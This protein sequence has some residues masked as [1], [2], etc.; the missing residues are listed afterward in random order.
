MPCAVRQG[1]ILGG[2][3]AGPV[4]PGLTCEDW[5]PTGLPWRALG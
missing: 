1:S 2:S 4:S 5:R 3:G